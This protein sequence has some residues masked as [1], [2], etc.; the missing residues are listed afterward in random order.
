MKRIKRWLMRG[1]LL[2]LALVLAVGGWLAYVANTRMPLLDGVITHPSLSGEVKITRDQWGIP[3]IQAQNAHDA[4]FAL[5]YAM[6]QDRLFQMEIVR[7]LAQGE[8]AEVAGP[9]AVKVDAIVRSFRLKQKADETIAKLSDQMPEIREV[10]EAFCAGIN[11]RQKNEPLPFEFV[12]LGIPA[13][14][15]T[16]ADCMSVG[17][18]LPIAFADGMREDPTYTMLQAKLP[19]VDLKELFP[20]YELDDVPTTVMES[21]DEARAY[22]E[23]KKAG[24]TAKSEAARSA[25]ASMLALNAILDPFVALSNLMGP[26]QVGSNSW[27]IGPSR[28]KSG[29]SILCNDP[30]IPFTNPSVWYEAHIN[31]PGYHWYGYHLPLIPFALIGHNEHHSW[32]LT[33]LAN[34]DIDLFKETFDP[35]NPLRVKYLNEWT[36]V[37]VEEETIRVR[38]GADRTVPIRI[39]PHGPVV[40]DFIR[41]T[42]GYEGPEV[43]LSWV[44]Q[45]VDYTDLQAFYKMSRATSLEEFQQAVSLVTSPGLNISYADTNGNIAWWA[46]GKIS[47]RPEN[48]FYKSILEGADGSAERLGFVPFEQ[49]PHLINPPN[50]YIV[51]ANNKSTVKPVGPIADMQG[52]WQPGDRAARIKDMLDQRSDWDAESLKQTIYDDF[53]WAAPFVVKEI[54]AAVDASGATLSETEAAAKALLASWDF[55]HGVDSAG[56][57]VYQYVIDEALHAVVADE[58]GDKLFQAYTTFADHWNSFKHL[59]KTDSPFWDDVNTSEKETRQQVLA[60]SFH[61]AVAK[62]Q[63]RLGGRPETWAWGKIHTMEFKHPFGFIPG[64]GGLFNLGPYPSSGGAQI[65]NNMLYRPGVHK[66]DVLAGPSTRRIVDFAAPEKALSIIPTGNSGN[67]KSPNYGDQAEMFMTGKF[68][69]VNFTPEQVAEDKRHELVLKPGA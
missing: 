63:N 61:T 57:S 52:Y 30:H 41:F 23:A 6:G 18:L 67:F 11:F 7:R 28:T 45:R 16:P 50:G 46:A 9:L 34:D 27:V 47:I 20:S 65:V 5:G 14:E 69:E 58:M 37:K 1:V 40:T 68:R 43:A 10:S 2:V 35:A 60:R 38:F 19:G 64:L 54:L 4:Y 53:A 8:I 3:H 17:A 32:A 36:D 44:W 59:V 21:H 22:L 42:G 15:F 26:A 51:T 56:A 62:L 25:D 39:T 49:N 13:H 31:Y 33:M 24:A 12:A 55:H 48:V 29:E 66:Y